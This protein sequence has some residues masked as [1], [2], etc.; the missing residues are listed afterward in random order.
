MGTVEEIIKAV[1]DELIETGKAYLAL[2][3]VNQLLVS[4]HIISVAEKHSQSIKKLLEENKISHAYK[5]ES[6]PRQWRI[7]L[8]EEGKKRQITVQKKKPIKQ[9]LT[10]KGQ[11]SM[12]KTNY[13]MAFIAIGVFGAVVLPEEFSIIPGIIMVW[14][15]I[16]YFYNKKQQP[17]FSMKAIIVDEELYKP[18]H[19][20]STGNKCS[21]CDLRNKGCTAYICEPQYR[22]DKEH[23]IWRKM[24]SIDQLDMRK[25]RLTELDFD[26][27]IATFVN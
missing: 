16:V 8:S 6:P 15:V 14:G 7:P 4:T 11:G 10:K 27:W 17:V 12:K 18:V 2:G 19:I 22:V 5:T 24:G 9:G 13:G 26:G 25:A 21:K 3:Q 23:V 20:V 1:D